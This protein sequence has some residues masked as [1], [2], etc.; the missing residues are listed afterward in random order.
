[1]ELAVCLIKPDGMDHVREI[2]AYL[3]SLGVRVLKELRWCI[4]ESDV[5]VLY[6]A[7]LHSQPR[8]IER[9][10]QSMVSQCV[11]VLLCGKET[12][13]LFLLKSAKQYLRRTY[14]RDNPKGVVHTSDNKEEA[15]R[16][17]A[18]FFGEEFD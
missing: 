11:C 9:V 7:V 10:K 18:H 8:A 16:E 2:Q 6:S 15:E 4:Q 12:D 14:M 5:E 1:M 3:D 17:V 13:L